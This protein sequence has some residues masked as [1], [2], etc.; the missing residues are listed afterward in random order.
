[1]WLLGKL[2]R[3]DIIIPCQAHLNDAG[4]D[5]YVEKDMTI[6]K[7]VNKIGL[8]FK[9][10]LPPGMMAVISPRSS[11]MGVLINGFVPIDSQYSGEWNFCFFNM[12][13]KFKVKKGDRIGQVVFLE[14]KYPRITTDEDWYNE[15]I[16]GDGGFGSTGK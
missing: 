6:Q 3:K 7:G 1:M 5:V 4:Y 9:L 14:P 10:P 15:N 2:L 13:K 16:R 12:G 8:G 11:Y